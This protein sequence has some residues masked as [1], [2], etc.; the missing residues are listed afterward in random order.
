M[1]PFPAGAKISKQSGPIRLQPGPVVASS[2][3]SGDEARTCSNTST[4]CYHV[5]IHTARQL[6]L[7]LAPKRL[8][9]NLWW[10][11]P[12]RALYL[13]T[14]CSHLWTRLQLPD[15][16]YLWARLQLPLKQD[17]S[18]T[19]WA[20]LQLP[21]EQD[22]SH[23]LSKTTATS[24]QD[25]SHLWARLQDCACRWVLH[26]TRISANTTT[27]SWPQFVQVVR[28]NFSGAGFSFWSY[29]HYL[30]VLAELGSELLCSPCNM[31]SVVWW[32]G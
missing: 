21:F 27:L 30:Y 24:E 2:P 7:N 1:S 20:R 13:A 19:S 25:C 28:P 9:R 14:H 12:S 16:S 32:C 11:H 31:I 26:W 5:N 18:Y 17:C 4:P 15:C 29:W 8:L 3:A 23:L 6:C 22:Y 10:R